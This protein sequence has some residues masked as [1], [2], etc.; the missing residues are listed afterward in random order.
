MQSALHAAATIARPTSC[1][2]ARARE[3]QPDID[4]RNAESLGEEI[5]PVTME[6]DE[7]IDLFV[8]RSKLPASSGISGVERSR[9]RFGR[10]G[11][12]SAT[13]CSMLARMSLRAEQPLR[14]ATSC[15]LRCRSRG[16]SMEVRMAFCSMLHFAP[17]DLNKSTE[18]DRNLPVT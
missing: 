6:L 8:G 7:L 15:S 1:A 16:R 12:A 5:G 14:A 9:R 11:A 17:S 4:V 13:V 10:A 18:L 2:G 3:R